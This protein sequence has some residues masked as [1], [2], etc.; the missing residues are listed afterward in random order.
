MRPFLIDV[1]PPSDADTDFKEFFSQPSKT[2][3]LLFT[4]VKD[5]QPT[6]TTENYIHQRLWKFVLE[7]EETINNVSQVQTQQ[8]EDTTQTQTE[9]LPSCLNV[10]EI[11]KNYKY[12]NNST[13]VQIYSFIDKL[14]FNVIT[15]KTTFNKTVN[16]TNVYTSINKFQSSYKTIVSQLKSQKDGI[17]HI[18]STYSVIPLEC[19]ENGENTKIDVIVIVSIPQLY[20]QMMSNKSIV[21]NTPIT[22]IGIVDKTQ[23]LEDDLQFKIHSDLINTI[24][25]Q[26]KYTKPLSFTTLLR[27]LN[28]LQKTMKMNLRQFD[29]EIDYNLPVIR[30]K[31]LIDLLNFFHNKPVGIMTTSVSRFVDNDRKLSTQHMIV[32]TPVVE[33]VTEETEN[34]REITTTP[35]IFIWNGDILNSTNIS[36]IVNKYVNDNNVLQKIKTITKQLITMDKNLE[37]PEN[38]MTVIGLKSSRPLRIM[39]EIIQKSLGTIVGE[40]SFSIQPIYTQYVKLLK[41]DESD[42]LTSFE[43][44][45]SLLVMSIKNYSDIN[46]Q[47]LISP[48]VLTSFVTQLSEYGLTE[49]Q[50]NVVELVKNI[51]LP[52]QFKKPILQGVNNSNPLKLTL[53]DENGKEFETEV[54]TFGDVFNLQLEMTIKQVNGVVVWINSSINTYGRF[55]TFI[56]QYHEKLSDGEVKDIVKLVETL[57]SRYFLR[58][59]TLD[60][61]KEIMSTVKTLWDKISSRNDAIGIILGAFNQAWDDLQIFRD[62][63]K[64]LIQTGEL[65]TNVVTTNMYKKQSTVT[66][67]Q[68]QT[69]KPQ[70]QEETLPKSESNT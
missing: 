23:N 64:T 37:F 4:V 54:V 58:V 65:V 50:L 6:N 41:I 66:N 56:I 69:K 11:L 40:T 3:E 10:Q 31:Q 21:I 7:D 13:K 33:Y 62:I 51:T 57:T 63:T 32:N 35:S 8:Q 45:K 59:T 52:S 5:I 34:Y 28:S 48:K 68:K 43:S 19:T 24:V 14:I 44:G 67:Q 18:I 17:P 27:I 15:N 46:I 1:I 61:L 60:V 22:Y 12:N 42:L 70:E 38:K 20:R 39:G 9:N 36:E 30:G 53:T 16:E 55:D 29:D 49:K 2:V 25:E 26:D 47:F